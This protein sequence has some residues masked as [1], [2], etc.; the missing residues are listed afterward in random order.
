MARTDV[1]VLI[2]G[3]NGTG[4][5]KLAEVI[6]LNSARRERPFVKVNLGALPETLLEAELFGA[7]PGAFTGADKRRVGRFETAD[8]GTL[9]LDE[10][11]TLSAA[12]QVRLLRVLQT[13]EFERLGSSDTRRVDVRVLAAT[14][15]DLSAAIAAGRF[16]EDLYFRLNVIEIELPSLAERPADVVP[17]AE[18]FL[19][20]HSLPGEPPRALGD[21]ARRALL[22]HPWPGN[23]RE[24]E[25]AIRRASASALGLSRQALYRRMARLGMKLEKRLTS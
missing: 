1:P 2:T 3:G 16:R 12:G 8:G 24:L 18:H 23:I 5:E 14:N 13:G 11:G 22:E 4:K 9:L 6:V 10:I 17:L 15:A 7:E 19:Q 20:L 25:N 21:D